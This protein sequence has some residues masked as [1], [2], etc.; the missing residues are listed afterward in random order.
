MALLNAVRP[1]CE[2]TGGSV[3]VR[4]SELETSPL[5]QEGYQYWNDLHNLPRVTLEDLME[6]FGFDW[7][8]LLKLDCEGSE[9]SILGETPSLDRIGM[10]VGEYHGRK[11]WDA[12]R[13]KRLANWRYR[14]WRESGEAGGLFHYENPARLRRRRRGGRTER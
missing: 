8:D 4:E 10:I 11:R 5:R 13:I 3:V 2:S 14:Q 9:L 1:H 12:L 6:H 7:I